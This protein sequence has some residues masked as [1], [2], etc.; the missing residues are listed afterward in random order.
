MAPLSFPRSKESSVA[1]Q[2]DSTP[3][4]VPSIPGWS[5][6]GRKA[7]AT[8][9]ARVYGDAM[10]REIASQVLEP[11]ELAEA[12][13]RW[14][15]GTSQY[16]GG[17]YTVYD[18]QS[19]RV[20]L[21]EAKMP[22]AAPVAD[23]TNGRVGGSTDYPAADR[24]STVMPRIRRWSVDEDHPLV[25]VLDTRFSTA[26][27]A[28]AVVSSVHDA[29]ALNDEIKGQIAAQTILDP[30]IGLPTRIEMTDGA[31]GRVVIIEGN[32]RLGAAQQLQGL[33]PH[34]GL[35]GLQQDPG[36]APRRGGTIAM[37]SAATRHDRLVDAH[38]EIEELAGERLVDLTDP[39]Q[40]RL[41]TWVVKVL[42][43]IGWEPHP[44]ARDVTLLD[45]LYEYLERRHVR[46][47]KQWTPDASVAW[48]SVGLLDT[49]ERD[50]YIDEDQMF[51]WAGERPV[52][53]AESPWLDS[54]A[55]DVQRLMYRASTDEELKQ[56]LRPHLG[57]R[58]VTAQ[59]RA[60][61]V[62]SIVL[63]QRTFPSASAYRAAASAYE[64]ALGAYRPFWDGYVSLDEDDPDELAESAVHSLATGG[65]RTAA[66]QLALRALP[67]LV[68][69]GGLKRETTNDTRSPASL[70]EGAMASPRG[71]LFLA[72]V[73]ARGREGLPPRQVAETG[74]PFQVANGEWPE[75]DDTWLREELLARDDD[76]AEDDDEE[77]VGAPAT[78]K[79]PD[80]QATVAT[81]TISELLTDLLDSI[82]ALAQM[83]VGGYGAEADDAGED[84]V[85]ETP[86]EHDA[87][88]WVDVNGIRDPDGQIRDKA[89]QLQQKLVDLQVWGKVGRNARSA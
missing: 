37:Q 78:P 35:L 18:V 22:V 24:A 71:L 62:G 41:R 3:P 16:V 68:L 9:L 23:P 44:Y 27:T 11:D 79:S 39:E 67:Y 45:G 33:A 51:T 47:P 86:D 49:L 60:R 55:V 84:E 87:D 12:I 83:P 57:Q 81:Q 66:Q 43:P 88:T 4:P 77:G 50:G 69:Y 53:D 28:S 65:T 56:V 15:D 1:I 75:A 58:Y 82:D 48:D 54:L 26:Q 46:P 13:G 10:A 40:A 74:L 25:G 5:T 32:T 2:T 36:T 73:V 17:N 63:R 76:E 6:R 7:V 80:E 8:R 14:N 34:V 64:R 59:A 31:A 19:G 29:Q 72:D 61:L 70:L 20:T 21:V 42:L 52:D 38:R 30:I 85:G 89:H